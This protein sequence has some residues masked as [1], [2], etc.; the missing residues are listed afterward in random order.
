MIS[1]YY[2]SIRF[3]FLIERQIKVIVDTVKI[4]IT[5]G[6]TMYHHCKDGSAIGAGYFA[7]TK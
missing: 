4:T 1:C 5:M 6:R 2:I 3:L 7:T